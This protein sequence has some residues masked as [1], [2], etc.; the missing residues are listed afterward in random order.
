MDSSP[1]GS[2]V[3][4][5]LQARILEWVSISFSRDLPDPGI[6]SGSLALQAESLPNKLQGK[7]NKMTSQLQLGFQRLNTLTFLFFGFFGRSSWL[8]GF[9]GS[10]AGKESACNAGDASSIPGSGRSPGGGH[11]N[12][13]QY[14][15]LETPHGPR[16]LV[17]YSPWGRKELDTTERLST[18]EYMS[19]R[20]LVPQPGIEPG[21]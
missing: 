16:S 11:G 19:C 7:P 4:G 9:H 13:V 15:C 5:I 2:S 21:S 6:E 17:G 1:P 10:S 3:H 18:A 12:P 8:V 14:S 20:I